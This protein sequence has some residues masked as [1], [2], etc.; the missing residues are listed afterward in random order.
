MKFI[1]HAGTWHMKYGQNRAS[2]GVGYNAATG[3]TPTL[4]RL[5]QDFPDRI[6]STRELLLKE[7]PVSPFSF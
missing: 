2:L 5:K 1:K 4:K 3:G 6:E 7:G